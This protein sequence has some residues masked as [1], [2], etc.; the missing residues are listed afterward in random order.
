[1]PAAT[2]TIPSTANITQ[3]GQLVARQILRDTNSEKI[4]T[5]YEQQLACIIAQSIISQCCLT[6]GSFGKET[7]TE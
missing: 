7:A 4:V 5:L 3:F 1:M 6:I 2:Q